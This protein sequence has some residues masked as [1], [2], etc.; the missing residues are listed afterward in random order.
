M[1]TVMSL[2]SKQGRLSKEKLPES[3]QRQLEQ[4]LQASQSKELQEEAFED[5]MDSAI[6]E[7]R[8]RIVALHLAAASKVS[9]YPRMQQ[10]INALRQENSNLRRG[11]KNH[12]TS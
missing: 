7:F 8:E 4:L 10:L 2:L 12:S 1:G 9:S 6:E 3:E 5:E 11:F